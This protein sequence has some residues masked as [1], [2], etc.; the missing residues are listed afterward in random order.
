MRRNFA[1]P[2]LGALLGALLS[3]A[4]AAQ[5]STLLV[6]GFDSDTVHLVDA[7]SGAFLGSLGSVPGA[8]SATYGPDGH[9]Y[10]TSEKTNRVLRFDGATGAPLGAIVEDDP[11]T[12][13]DETG[14]LTAP[15]A[16]VFGPD[17]RLYVA[18][19]DGDQ[20]LV[21]DGSTGEYDD[22]FVSPGAGNLDGPD[23][24]M[25]FG[26]DGLL[27]VPSFENNRI[28][29]FDPT[30]GDFVDKFVGAGPGLRNPRM[31]RFRSDGTVYVSSWGSNRIL[32]FDLDAVLLDEFVTMG[33]PTGF[34]FEPGTGH[35]LVTSDNSDAVTR[36]DGADG[37]SLGDVVAP[38]GGVI[39]GG[40]FVEWL[41]D[42]ELRLSRL[43]PGTA[44][45]VSS[46]TVRGATPD[47]AV[48][49]LFGSETMSL[50]VDACQPAWLGVVSLGA[51]VV[52]ADG[53][54]AAVASGTLGPASVGVSLVL[55]AY[56]PA[57][58]RFSNLVLQTVAP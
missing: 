53:D 3:P 55:S 36:F 24:G 44:G 54:G 56:D 15:T 9:L 27:W 17:G 13:E 50:L 14:G 35:L 32:R 37:S 4:L 11:G 18:S 7:S 10:V 5:S 19:F 21:Y 43:A 49:L 29:R 8:Q 16:A 30:T 22:V 57:D 2:L 34:A 58:C 38:S 41:P 6:S 31:I 47:G 26:P 48:V 28:L 42:P 39:D 46:V 12:A 45:S 52:V 33:R 20:V 1:P 40:T 25:T 23:A 51:A